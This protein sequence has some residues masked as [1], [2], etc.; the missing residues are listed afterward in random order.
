MVELIITSAL[1]PLAD[2]RVYPDTA[3]ADTPM[4]FITFQQVGGR[5]VVFTDG[6]TADKQGARI[7]INV[8]AKSR[9]KSSALMAAVA[10]TLC[11]TPVLAL[12]QGGAVSVSDPVTGFKGAT[13]DFEIWYDT[14]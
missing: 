2:G 5:P 12:P 10:K 3:D 7:Q 6:A 1:G 4:P 14:P 9:L 11:A 13:Q 8:W